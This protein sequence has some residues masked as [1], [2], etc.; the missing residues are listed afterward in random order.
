MVQGGAWELV[1][2]VSRV[3]L[4]DGRV[5]GGDLTDLSAAVNWYM[6]ASTRLQLNYIYSMP[7]DQGRASIFL[8]RFQFQ[9]W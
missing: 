8:L 7:K 3:D 4:N 2:R 1:G 9:P 5:N 6:S